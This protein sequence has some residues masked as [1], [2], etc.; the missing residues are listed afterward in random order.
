MLRIRPRTVLQ[1]GDLPLFRQVQAVT[2]PQGESGDPET[3]EPEVAAPSDAEPEPLTETEDM[4][5]EPDPKEYTGGGVEEFKEDPDGD[6]ES[7]Q[8]GDAVGV[9]QDGETPAPTP[10]YDEGIGQTSLSTGAVIGIV[11]GAA[12]GA[13]LLTVLC[14][15]A[16]RSI[17]ASKRRARTGLPRDSYDMPVLPSRFTTGVMPANPA[18]AH[19]TTF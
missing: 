2:P 1:E 13:V 19:A 15:W 3:P 7:P 14:V 16:Y 6:D 4:E 5:T 17:S 8:A 9:A 12:L 18:R 10:R 11:C